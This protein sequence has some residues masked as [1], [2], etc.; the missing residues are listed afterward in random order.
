MKQHFTQLQ[1]GIP[2]HLGIALLALLLSA[3]AVPAAPAHPPSIPR[4]GRVA[5]PPTTVPLANY[6]GLRGKGSRTR[7][8]QIAMVAM[9][10]ALFIILRKKH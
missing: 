1:S 5:T 9:C 2:K 10:F 4:T 3:V 8:A 7:A 6:F